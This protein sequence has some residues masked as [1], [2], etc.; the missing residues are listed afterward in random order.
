[1]AELCCALRDQWLSLRTD[2]RNRAADILDRLAQPEP[3]GPT[4][5]EILKLTENVS[6]EY[7]CRHKSLPSDWDPGDYA[8]SAKGLIEFARAVLSRWGNQ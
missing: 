8:S 3:V 2:Q 4:D 5:D 1:V 7:L 6:T